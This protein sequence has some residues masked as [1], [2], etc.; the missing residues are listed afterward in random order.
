[1]SRPAA[2]TAAAD[3]GPA[4]AGRDGRPARQAGTQLVGRALALTLNLGA[5]AVLVRYLPATGFGEYTLALTVAYIGSLLATFG[6]DVSLFRRLS[7]EPDDAVTLARTV[8]VR[9]GFA[10][11]VTVLVVAGGH[12]ATGGG[13]LFAAIAAATLTILIGPLQTMA[14]VLRAR[15]QLLPFAIA[16]VGG[17]A[18]TLTMLLLL[19]RDGLSA[20]EAVVATVV[21]N[22]LAATF[23]AA[24]SVR[25]LAPGFRRAGLS[26]A[27]FRELLHRSRA[28][29][30]A[31]LVVVGYYRLDVLMLS[32][33]GG[34]AALGAYAVAYR[35][36]DVAMYVQVIVI[37]AFFPSM[38]RAWESGE[39]P[40][41]R[42][43]DVA[44]L[45]V[46]AG[47]AIYVVVISLGPDVLALVSP[48]RYP[49]LGTLLPLLLAATVVMYVNRLLLQALIAGGRGGAQLRCWL[50]ALATSLV[51][52]PLG[53]VVA[54]AVG[55][56]A[57]TLVAEL[58]LLGAAAHALRDVLRR[59]PLLT[60]RRP[61]ILLG[62][63]AL[64]TAA[65]ALGPAP[66]LL[67][68]AV[69]AATAV[70]MAA[71]RYRLQREPGPA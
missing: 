47:T 63:A 29:G 49:D 11:A 71:R 58:V 52:M 17:S 60:G 38:A 16:D 41:A 69:V 46:P 44:A 26:V 31:D 59:R 56:A 27:G 35:F 33:L 18:V 24:L 32:A 53:V 14:Q 15:V 68:A 30:V 45:L 6:L 20:L 62:G 8:V 23:L 21:P 2:D 1:V 40:Q 64:V 48:E 34:L 19:S 50:V 61:A 10:V 67:G 57:A 28:L 3:R 51:A 42:I 36:V 39:G 7:L 12:A 4:G 66:Q 65:A 70:A 37:G 43:E 22:A 25:R 54:G 9:C 5:F 55:A 13:P